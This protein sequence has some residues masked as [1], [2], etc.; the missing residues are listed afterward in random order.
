MSRNHISRYSL[1]PRLAAAIAAFLILGVSRARAETVV[2]RNGQS[3]S[4]TGYEQSGDALVLHV[5]GGMVTLPVADVER[6]EPQ[7]E[8]PPNPVPATPPLEESIR[9]VAERYRLDPDL[10]SSV[11]AVESK[12]DPRAVSRKNAQGLMQLMPATSTRMGVAN[13]F[14]ARQNLEGGA[15]YL[16]ELLDRYKQDVRLALAAYNAGPGPV[17]R[18]HGVPYIPETRMYVYQVMRQWNARAKNTNAVV[19]S[20]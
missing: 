17:D 13:A 7:L 6:I 12:F 11:I 5:A 19:A 1:L 4:V 10:L 9:D 2:L 18:V 14:D 15:R 8:F 20:R 16:R 3:L